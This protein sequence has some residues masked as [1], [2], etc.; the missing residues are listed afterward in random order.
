MQIPPAVRWGVI[1]CAIVG[2]LSMIRHGSPP[3][4]SVSTAPSPHAE[5]QRPPSHP[6][7]MP[8]TVS[9]PAEQRSMPQASDRGYWQDPSI[10]PEVLERA[11]EPPRRSLPTQAR[12]QSSAIS[13]SQSDWRHLQR[14]EAA[15]V[16]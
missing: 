5:L 6:A 3:Q 4:T 14:D 8:P 2:G 10:D 1:G 13:P 12:P 11:F 15:V 7:S 16:Y 9:T